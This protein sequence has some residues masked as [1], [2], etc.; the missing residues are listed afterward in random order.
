MYCNYQPYLGLLC[1]GPLSSPMMQHSDKQTNINIY[2]I[3]IILISEEKN[4][5]EDTN[6]Y[7]SVIANII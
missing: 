4:I 3:K 7:L 5:I 1:A 2:G 6:V